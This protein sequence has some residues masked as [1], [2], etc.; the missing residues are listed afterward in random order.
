MCS[1]KSGQTR[2]SGPTSTALFRQSSERK[3]MVE[4]EN[5]TQ[6]S[7]P[8]DLV[9]KVSEL[10]QILGEAPG[11]IVIA[12]VDHF[13]ILPRE[14]QKAVLTAAGMRRRT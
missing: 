10:S 7:L 3:S 9:E 14:R 13:T 5:T 4:R 2:G 11:D 8:A 1:P 12:A 6:V